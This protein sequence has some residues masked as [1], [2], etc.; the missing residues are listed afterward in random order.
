MLLPSSASSP[1]FLPSR[2]SRSR[3]VWAAPCHVSSMGSRKLRLHATC[4]NWVLH[5]PTSFH[6]S[7][8][9]ASRLPHVPSPSLFITVVTMGP[10]PLQ[11]QWH[12]LPLTHWLRRGSASCNILQC[13]RLKDSPSLTKGNGTCW[14][15]KESWLNRMGVAKTLHRICDSVC[16][17][18]LVLFV[19]RRQLCLVVDAQV[20]K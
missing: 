1:L 14:C 5:G 2:S 6:P 11:S 18:S 4:C 17:G 10:L 9:I 16:S 12:H 7:R 20:L 13:W 3:L 15:R 19:V 8:K